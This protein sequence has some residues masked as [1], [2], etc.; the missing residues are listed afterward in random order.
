MLHKPQTSCI[1]SS[2]SIAFMAGAQPE[3]LR[4]TRSGS[5]SS[6]NHC[7]FLGTPWKRD[8]TRL[9]KVARFLDNNTALLKRSS[10]ALFKK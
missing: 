5:G 4:G 1:G 2:G 3:I 9:I 7:L 10:G 8:L 6:G